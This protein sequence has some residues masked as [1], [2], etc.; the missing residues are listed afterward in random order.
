MKLEAQPDAAERPGAVHECPPSSHVHFL[1]N[2]HTQ[3][4]RRRRY[5]LSTCVLALFGIVLMLVENE[6]VERKEEMSDT[7]ESAQLVLKICV[8]VSTV[9]LDVL[10]VLR[11]RCDGQVNQLRSSVPS[12]RAKFALWRPLLLLLELLICSFHIPPGIKGKV[13][14]VQLHGSVSLKD[15]SVCESLQ[16]GVNSVKRGDACYL[17]Y[18]YPVEVFGVF[19][20]LRLY[21]LARFVRSVSTFYSPWISLVGSL[22]GLDAMRPFFHF[23]AIFKLHPLNVLLPLAVL[24][25]LLTAAIVRVLERPVQAAFDNYWRAVWFTI[26]TLSG[27]GLGDYFPVT[28]LGRSFAVVGGMFCGVLIVA[29]IQ[30]IFF[31]FLDL[32]PS[33]KKVRYLIEMEWWEKATHQNAARL[34]QAAWCT[35]ILRH[36]ARQTDQRQLYARMRV[37]RKLRLEKPTLELSIEDQVAEMEATV[38]AEVERLEAQKIAILKRIQTKAEQLAV[39]KEVLQT[40]KRER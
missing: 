4:R 36:D 26:V 18:Q 28:S 7:S 8:L 9:L 22:N 12:K 3:F 5:E 38:L 21:L 31:N 29:L 1:S 10:L 23:K 39:L 25:A 13:E 6:V 20:V 35:G 14:I 16:W 17:V 33:E 19:M 24:N 27:T 32:S 15:D 30:S 2:V 37:A 40:K 11:Y 34:L